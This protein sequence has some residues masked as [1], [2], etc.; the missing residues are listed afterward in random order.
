MREE[1]A[2]RQQA[3]YR[4]AEALALR[5]LGPGWIPWMKLT[6]VSADDC[7]PT[8]KDDPAPFPVAVAYK[9]TCGKGE[10]RL[11]RFLRE[12][13][14]GEVVSSGWYED[15][16]CGLLEE[17][18]PTRTVEVGGRRVPG[19]R[20]QLYWSAL[21]L[22]HPR[23]A[24]QLAALR[25]SRE[26]KKAERAEKKWAADNPLLAWAERANQDEGPEEQ[27]QRG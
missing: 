16:F 19:K 23:S 6:L 12:L 20:Y 8:G 9:V 10:D 11:D 2:D 25:V 3:E 27:G 4:H 26:R 13:P 5:K 7:R 1:I 24:D 17:K 18:H 15:V 21:E 14:T 22:Y